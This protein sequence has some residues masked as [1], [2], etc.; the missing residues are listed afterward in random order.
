MACCISWY[1][2]RLWLL[3][4]S[5]GLSGCSA[6]AVTQCRTHE[7]KSN[8]TCVPV[9]VDEDEKIQLAGGRKDTGNTGTTKSGPQSVNTNDRGDAPNV[10]VLRYDPSTVT[11]SILLSKL[12][13]S[14]TEKTN[15]VSKSGA[16]GLPIRWEFFANT[17]QENGDGML[18][19]YKALG[20]ADHLTARAARNMSVMPDRQSRGKDL[21]D[22][23]YIPNLVFTD[24][25]GYEELGTYR[26]L[27]LTSRVYLDGSY[28]KIKFVSS[29]EEDPA[30]ETSDQDAIATMKRYLG[31]KA[32]RIEDIAFTT[33][34][35]TR[36]EDWRFPLT[37]LTSLHSWMGDVNT[38]WDEEKGHV[39]SGDKKNE[40][41]CFQKLMA[42]QLDSLNTQLT[43]GRGGGSSAVY[44]Y[45]EITYVGEDT[46]N[47]LNF[48][49]IVIQLD[50]GT[51]KERY[52][53]AYGD[54]DEHTH[55]NFVDNTCSDGLIKATEISED[56]ENGERSESNSPLQLGLHGAAYMINASPAHRDRSFNSRAAPREDK[57]IQV[58]TELMRGASSSCPSPPP[59]SDD[60]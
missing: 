30:E 24:C 5:I 32:Y 12:A 45:R 1:H 43:A 57:F 41:L 25:L 60:N 51:T 36:P 42:K 2:A 9:A 4:L 6:S 19:V 29:F 56:G 7:V 54:D 38:K 23:K 14:A 39:L 3:W 55:V 8:G 28:V 50:D 53:Y 35:E 46:D 47:N 13:L 21:V 17:W 33:P 10:Q 52:I 34:S 48:E 26:D 44:A 31:L 20:T 40:R 18:K 59:S 15:L 27:M 16:N 37:S 22:L 11:F 49:K 58:M